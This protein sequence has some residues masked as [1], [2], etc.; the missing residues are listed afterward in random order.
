MIL[1][2]ASL[3]RR[4]ISCLVVSSLS[5]ASIVRGQD[6]A[7]AV[8]AVAAQNVPK[9]PGIHPDRRFE[10]DWSV[11]ADPRV[12]REPLDGLKYIPLR[13]P[14]TFLSLGMNVRER[15]E[16]NHS[17]FFG[18]PPGQGGRWILSR[19]ELHSD[20][21]IASHVQI[22][23]QLQNENAPGKPVPGPPDQNKLDFEQAFIGVTEPMSG[24]TARLRIGRQVLPMDF[25]RFVSIRE[26]PNV[27][28][29]YDAVYADYQRGPWRVSGGS[30]HPVETRDRSAFDD[31]SSR[32]FTFS[33]VRIQR[34]ISGS[35]VT[36]LYALYSRDAAVFTSVSGDERRHVADIR[37]TGAAD[38]FDW[39]I[40]GMS[41][42]G[43]IAGQTIA[44]AA[45]GASVGYTLDAVSLTPRLGLGVDIATGDRNPNDNRLETF[46]PLFPNG[47]Y[48]ADYTGFPN[49][50]HV[51]PA[52]TLHP[53]PVINV[54]A[55]VAGQWRETTADAV[56]VFPGVPV[57]GTA[58]S[59]GRYTGTYGEVRS[60]W[61][62][63]PHY[64]VLLDVIHY[65]I[66][67][68]V[69]R[70]GG[71]DANYFGLQVSFAW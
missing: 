70:A 17:T 27:R 71:H 69:R 49:L 32:R 64:S 14:G 43:R 30:T 23:A 61:T 47:Y 11:L 28:Q 41:Q 20:L 18:I 24:G 42:H 25:Q 57:R 58:G 48:L 3:S 13:F 19:V 8:A 66:G 9:R 36:G 44:A 10:E 29:S 1:A 65:A 16:L 51:R 60:T 26:G 34:R 59:P 31:F 35:T 2:I 7:Q 6:S 53:T 50:I 46:N 55:A 63:A 21:R 5:T 67:D 45:T 37:F 62:I 12:A 39:D 22:F 56:Y 33:S 68:A 38:G 4:K 54:T 15:G 40:E 52:V